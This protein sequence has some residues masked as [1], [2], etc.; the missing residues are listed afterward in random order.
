MRQRPNARVR[1]DPFSTGNFG[2]RKKV[3][4]LSENQLEWFLFFFSAG[5]IEMFV[6]ETLHGIDVEQVLS[7]FVVWVPKC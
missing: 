5:L 4:F 3:Q 2:G 1:H 7:N 6:D